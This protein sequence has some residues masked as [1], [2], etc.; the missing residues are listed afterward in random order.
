MSLLPTIE[1]MNEF[2]LCLVDMEDAGIKIDNVEL[3]RLIVEY[4]KKVQDLEVLLQTLAQKAMG[5]TEINLNSPEQLSMLLYSRKVRDKKQWKE[6]FELDR[7]FP[8][9]YPRPQFVKIV[10]GCTETVYR[11]KAKPCGYCRGTGV[12]DKKRK[13][14]SSYKRIPRCFNCK[15][16]GRTFDKTETIAGFKLQPLSSAE[17]NSLGFITDKEQLEKLA[18]RAKTDDA[19][20]FLTS[21]V[22]YNA[23]TVYLNTYL[24]GIRKNTDKNGFLH[25]QFM[26]CVARTGRL[27]SVDP[28]FQNQPRSS[29]FPIRKVV[30]SRFAGGKIVKA[31][32]AQ[33]E[34]RVAVE[35]ADDKQGKEDIKNRVDVHT[36]TATTLTDAGQRTDRQGAKSHTFKPLYGGLSG[37]AAE[38]TYY[39][40]FLERYSDIRR[41]HERLCSLALQK[42]GISIPSG[43]IYKFPF[44]RRYPNGGVSGS[45]K[46]KNYPVQG[47]ATADI[48]PISLIEAFR[49]F[50]EAGLRSVIFLTV[51]DEHVVDAP[52]EEVDIA[53]KLLY[54]S[55]MSVPRLL[56]ERYGYEITVPLDVEVSVGD[57]WMETTKYDVLP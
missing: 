48:V 30:V 24:L 35:L 55:M 26:Q 41:W 49:Q 47:F 12:L 39:K 8:K 45:T 23:Y 20:D 34:F 54:N 46:I 51:H 50:K 43:R 22:Q 25:T 3:E 44:A 16:A 38:V 57:N 18:G 5:D 27:S 14:G 13:D 31:D 40:W 4:T 15:G 17:V 29:T 53:A 11:T 28:N 9:S 32:F 7:K 10:T 2:S 1:M 56:K 33:L 21:M 36:N 6:L 52:P 19:K 42:S 37:T